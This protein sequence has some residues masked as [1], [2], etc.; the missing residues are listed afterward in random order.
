MNRELLSSLQTIR[1]IGWRK[2]LFISSKLGFGYPFFIGNMNLY[3]FSLLSFLLNY[4]VLSEVV[5][6]RSLNSIIRKLK[7]LG[8]YS[9]MRHIDSLPVHGQRTRTNS[10]SV[11]KRAYK[12]KNKNTV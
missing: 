5:I 6:K 11:R 2:S 3:H 7:L 4:L 9:G 1:G 12:P 8:H 10:R